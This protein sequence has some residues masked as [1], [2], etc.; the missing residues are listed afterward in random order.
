MRA[1]LDRVFHLRENGTTVGT[2]VTGG[3]ATSMPMPYIR[4]VNPQILLITI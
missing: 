2:E 3:A 1:F 4:V